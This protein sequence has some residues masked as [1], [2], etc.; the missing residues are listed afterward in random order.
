[1]HACEYVKHISTCPTNDDPWLLILGAS[2]YEWHKKLPGILG[3]R[4]TEQEGGAGALP[5]RPAW[6]RVEGDL[7]YCQVGQSGSG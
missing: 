3:R 6:V 1:M 4:E 2:V 7:L 5:G